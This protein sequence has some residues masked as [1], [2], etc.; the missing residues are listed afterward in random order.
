[1]YAVSQRR[2]RALMTKVIFDISVSLDG[3][4]TAANVRPKKPQG[5][6]P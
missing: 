2:Y 4:M 3:F 6:W 1:M 5:D